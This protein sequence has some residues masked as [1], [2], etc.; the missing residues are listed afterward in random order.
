MYYPRPPSPEN[1]FLLEHARLLSENFQ[2]LLGKPLI[3][4]GTN[5]LAESLFYAPF[6]VLSHNTDKD[7]LFNYANQKALELFEL[8]WEQLIQL[9]SRESAEPVNREERSKLLAQV[10]SQGFVKDYRG[11]RIS[12]SG[13][14]FQISDAFI[15]NLHDN[16]GIYQGQ[17][18]CLYQW[19][20]L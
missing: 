20:F 12:S 9:P 17:A 18:A 8:S 11:V 14:R 4:A 13:K 5:E 19:T 2:R 7:P 15:W 3:E 16:N 1:Q 10:T 6:A